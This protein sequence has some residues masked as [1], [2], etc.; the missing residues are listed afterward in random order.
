MA[1]WHS[2]APDGVDRYVGRG[3]SFVAMTLSFVAWVA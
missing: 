2:I 1:D 3:L